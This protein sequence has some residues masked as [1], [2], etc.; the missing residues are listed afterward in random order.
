MQE[1]Q[2]GTIPQRQGWTKID[3]ANQE[4]WDFPHFDDIQDMKDKTF[5][6]P[7]SVRMNI[8]HTLNN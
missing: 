5:V 1:V 3:A 7:H 8:L 6:S 2:A 4:L